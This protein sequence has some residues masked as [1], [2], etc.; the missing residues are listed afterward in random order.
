M[1]DISRL[2]LSFDIIA[3][4]SEA[5]VLKEYDVIVMS[6][7]YLKKCCIW[8]LQALEEQLFFAREVTFVSSGI[9]S[10]T[11]LLL[12]WRFRVTV[13]SVWAIHIGRRYTQ[14]Q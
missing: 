7:S 8:L 13:S 4:R 14:Q 3:T 2:S 5:L 12:L 11:R 9:M 6:H 1:K 10:Q